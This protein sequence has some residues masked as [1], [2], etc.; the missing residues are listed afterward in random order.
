MPT[1]SN[2]LSR[3]LR[4]LTHRW[5][6]SDEPALTGPGSTGDPLVDRVLASR[7]LTDSA[8][9]DAFCNPRL[10]HLHDP[11]LIPDLDRAAQRVINACQSGETIAIWGDYDVDGV[12][13]AAILKHTATALAPS[14]TV[15]TYIPHRGDEGYGLNADGLRTLADSGASVVIT[16]DCG[17]TA[18]READL[19]RSLGIDLIITDHHTPPD[20]VEDLPRA[21]AVVHP[22]RPGSTYPFPDLTGAGVAYKLAWRLATLSSGS[23]RVPEP[24]RTLLIEMLAPAAMGTIADVAPLVGENRVIAR[25]GLARIRAT[26]LLGLR[27]LVEA[28]GL[29]GEHIG[30]DEVGFRL[31]PRLNACGRMGH[32]REAL[33]L[34]LTND[35]ARAVEIAR[36]LTRLNEERRAVETAITRQASALADDAGMTGADGR[37]IVLADETWH[38][39]VVG[40]VCSRLVDRFHRPAIV[41][42]RSGDTLHGSCR[43]IEGFD[44]HAALSACGEH[45]E[46]FGGHAMAAGLSL[47]AGRFNAFTNAF[48]GYARQTLRPD[49]LVPT[50]RVDCD[51]RLGDLT[52]ATVRRLGELGPFGRGN[53]RPRVRLTGL[54]LVEPPRSLGA[55]GKHLKLTVGDGDRMMRLVAWDWGRRRDA[56]H[57]GMTI[58]AVVEPRLNTWR[59]VETVEP[60]LRDLRRHE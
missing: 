39:G 22:G 1:T 12:T 7:G 21:Y 33:E 29:T 50:L 28:S 51:A 16:V 19:A 36:T 11:S 30:S 40:I 44:I 5:R 54:R 4:G 26:P 49:D 53:P 23:D 27:A 52:S 47:Q 6:L 57:R 48:L 55:E 13:A 45:L 46:T 9:I 15:L 24:L 20:R 8:E 59:G 2:D 58:D 38:A 17:V 25:F 42:Q 34:F 32:A 60:H 41:L 10:T 14:A 35:P 56:L 37:A 3:T 18:V 43:S 31:A